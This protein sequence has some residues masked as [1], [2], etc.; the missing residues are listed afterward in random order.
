MVLKSSQV[1]AARLMQVERLNDLLMKLSSICKANISSSR[2]PYAPTALIFV[3]YHCKRASLLF[4]IKTVVMQLQP[5]PWPPCLQYAPTTLKMI[6]H[7]KRVL[8][9]LPY[10][11]LVTQLQALQ[12]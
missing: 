11:S 6:Y 1:I 10:Q 9:A 8:S 4:H 2:I 5:S 7:C 3:P 12:C